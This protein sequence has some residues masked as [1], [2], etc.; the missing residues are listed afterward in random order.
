MLSIKKSFK[1]KKFKP[2][3]KNFQTQKTLIMNCQIHS[4]TK[5]FRSFIR[6]NNHRDV[7]FKVGVNIPYIKRREHNQP[8][9]MK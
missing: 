3:R 1:K 6:Y 4:K 8:N 5:S 2:K 7:T 9:T